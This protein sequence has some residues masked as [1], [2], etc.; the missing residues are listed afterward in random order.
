MDLPKEFLD[1]SLLVVAHA[2]DE[3]L[4]FSSIIDDVTKIVIVFGDE[5]TRASLAGHA[6]RDKIVS[7][8]LPQ[9]DCHNLSSWPFPEPTDYG[10]RLD[11]DLRADARYAEQAARVSSALS[12]LVAD[13]GNV[14]THNPWG[15]YGHESHVQL[16][17]I[18]TT[19]A[20]S[21]D[22]TVWHSNYVSGKSSRMMRRYVHGFADE[23]FTRPVDPERA[24]AIAD[25]YRQNN[26]WSF[27]DDFAWFP[28]ECF[29][30]GPLNGAAE[31]TVGTL[32]PVNY[33]RVPFDPVARQRPTP[34]FATRTRRK[35]SRL[36]GRTQ[37]VPG[38]AAAN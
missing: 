12:P 23:Y 5:T 19:L 36:F 31:P 16:S 33:V 25:T 14:F 30:R 21:R 18:V 27:D 28:S 22:A 7:L 6:C 29:L 26:A 17:R 3:V 20:I 1:Q 10:V 34:G 38:D 13:A 2:D 15:E 35:L 24:L 32:F 37:T 11:K 8:A 4:W 9:V